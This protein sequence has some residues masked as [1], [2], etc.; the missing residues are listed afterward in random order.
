MI[1]LSSQTENLIGVAQGFIKSIRNNNKIF[2]LSVDKNLAS[3]YF[4]SSR[5]HLFRIEK[6][7]YRSAICLNYTNLAR[8][9]NEK[10]S[11]LR[12]Y[13]IDKNAPVFDKSLS[14]NNI[15]KTKALF[16]GLNQSQQAAI[17]KV[18]LHSLNKLF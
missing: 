17:I 15:L 11:N 4:K 3:T 14:K 10:Y 8:L 16:K 5:E 2:L 18:S 13:I 9:M 12:S 7:N 6:T 1:L